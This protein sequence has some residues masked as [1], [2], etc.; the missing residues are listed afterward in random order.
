VNHF[1]GKYNKE[2]HTKVTKLSR[3]VLDLLVEYPWP[4]N[5]RELEN[6]IERAVVMSPGDSL[7]PSLLPSEILEHKNKDKKQARSQASSEI[8]QVR[9]ATERCCEA[10]GDLAASRETLMRTVEE[11]IIR[12]ALARG[13]SQRDLS[14]QVGLSR[15]TLRKRMKDYG[16]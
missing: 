10:S 9:R 13:I 1:L 4:G 3:D 2:N 16:L 6:C 14:K 12:S 5:V 11:T 7:L 15:M 8:S